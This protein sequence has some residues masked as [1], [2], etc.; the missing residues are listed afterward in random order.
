MSGD[1]DGRAV[2]SKIRG[3]K[4][5]LNPNGNFSHKSGDNRISSLEISRTHAVWITKLWKSWSNIIR[6]QFESLLVS[7]RNVIQISQ[8]NLQTPTSG[9]KMFDAGVKGNWDVSVSRIGTEM[10]QELSG[11][12]QG[13]SRLAPFFTVSMTK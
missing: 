5:G 1:K 8:T 3:V 13:Q 2:T 6:F 10:T 11:D 4:D 9:D 12:K 7:N